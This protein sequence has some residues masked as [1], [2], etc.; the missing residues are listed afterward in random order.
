MKFTDDKNYQLKLAICY[1]ECSNFKEKELL[2][3]RNIFSGARLG[4]L[5]SFRAY[6]T[7]TFDEEIDHKHECPNI[8]ELDSFVRGKTNC[9]I[10]DLHD[11]KTEWNF[12]KCLIYKTQYKNDCYFGYIF[13]DTE[14][15]IINNIYN[16]NFAL[17]E[18]CIHIWKTLEILSRNNKNLYYFNLN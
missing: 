10:F 4:E 11:S 17:D 12:K 7:I 5:L 6:G 16:V 13:Y 14:T 3:M 2:I 9:I 8:V 1:T 18:L 15:G